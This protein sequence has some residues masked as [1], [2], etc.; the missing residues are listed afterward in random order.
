MM[1]WRKLSHFKRPPVDWTH[2]CTRAV[3]DLL[4]LS[5]FRLK[6]GW[7]KLLHALCLCTLSCTSFLKSLEYLVLLLNPGREKILCVCACVRRAMRQPRCGVPDRV[8][9]EVNEGTRK[10]RYAVTGQR[11][12]KDHITYRFAALKRRV[13]TAVKQNTLECTLISPPPPSTA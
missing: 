11:W 1:S 2:L 8:A 10:K 13:Q 4:L 6:F 3:A 9:S 7:V 12:D 5:L